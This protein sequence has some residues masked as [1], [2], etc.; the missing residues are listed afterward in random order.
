MTAANSILYEKIDNKEIQKENL[1]AFIIDMLK[2]DE[3]V[4]NFTIDYQYYSDLKRLVALSRKSFCTFEYWEPTEKMK[5]NRIY[6]GRSGESWID[7]SLL[8]ENE[9]NEVLHDFDPTIKEG[10]LYAEY[11]LRFTEER[12]YTVYNLKLNK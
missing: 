1:R 2:L 8:S 3:G 10:V 12:P 9:V 7:I 4:G 6:G 11:W 5:E